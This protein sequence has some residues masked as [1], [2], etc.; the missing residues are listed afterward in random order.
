MLSK[1][2]VEE[3]TEKRTIID[4]NQRGH[5]LRVRVQISNGR[6]GEPKNM[7]GHGIRGDGQHFR[8]VELFCTRR[9]FIL[10]GAKV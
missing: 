2:Y 1:V 8:P 6:I 7:R 5:L 10:S 4:K 9:C 3:A